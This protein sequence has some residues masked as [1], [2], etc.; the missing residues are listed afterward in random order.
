LLTLGY[1]NENMIIEIPKGTSEKKV[2]SIL[3][4]KVGKRNPKKT[5][6]CFFGKLPDIEDGLKFQKKVRRE[7]K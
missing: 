4:Q 6:D 3:H 7:W 5:V 1:K 2:K